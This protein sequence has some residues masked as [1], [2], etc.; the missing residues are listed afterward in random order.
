MKGKWQDKVISVVGFG[1]GFMM[2]PQI[3]DSLNGISYV[4]PWSA[5]LTTLGL[6]TLAVC[7]YT[8]KMKISFLAECF[9]SF[10]WFITW[11]LSFMQ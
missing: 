6:L 5:G 8:L 3:M 9:V 1:F 10:T 2:I 11:L 4:N 7:F